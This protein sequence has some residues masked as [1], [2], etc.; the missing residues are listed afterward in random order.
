MTNGLSDTH[1]KM[2]VHYW[3]ENRDIT[4]YSSWDEIRDLVNEEYPD[5]VGAM[6]ERTLAEMHIDD[7]VSRIS[8]ESGF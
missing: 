1:K 7:I 2:V 6:M 4:R 8:Q 5:L 3:E